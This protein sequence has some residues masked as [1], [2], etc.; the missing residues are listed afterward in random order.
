MLL[1]KRAGIKITLL[2]MAVA[3]LMAFG[4]LTQANAL[5]STN[6]AIIDSP[7]VINGGIFPTSISG[8]T[9][10]NLAVADVNATN[11]AA[12]D[13]VLLNVASPGM[14]CSTGTLSTS[15]KQDLVDF[16]AN[17]GKLIIYDSECPTADY[18]WLPYPF[19]TNNPGALGAHG[20][21]TIVEENT[22]SCSTPGCTVTD[23]N[24]NIT[25]SYIDA[26]SLG[27]NTD[28]V[29]DM[30]V[31]VTRDPNWCL[32]MEGTNALAVEGPVHT[33]ATYY[34]GLIIYNGLDVDYMGWGTTDL[35]KIWELELEQ[36]W[37]PIPTDAATGDLVLPCSELVAC[38]PIALKDTA[39]EL[40]NEALDY[41]EDSNIAS[42]IA[43]LNDAIANEENALQEL[44]DPECYE[45]ASSCAL[46]AA[47]K[48]IG[49]AISRE[50]SAIRA[51]DRS[52][53]KV[54]RARYYIGSSIG[55]LQKADD[56][57]AACDG[58]IPSP[59]NH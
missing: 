44:Q 40:K 42:A 59:C 30:N 6:V 39:I 32:D 17:G 52:Q 49:R 24:G 23:T 15:Q 27:S 29:G 19:D 7:T 22:L 54:H 2:V 57:L 1:T 3:L 10:T 55:M 50:E 51:L 35:D 45:C 33:Y 8:I 56:Y 37:N 13:T 16:V 36:R 41:L 25:D 26:A 18:S 20:T 38:D 47:I 5:T 21:L 9:F 4:S 43:N 11:L 31:M 48:L 14:G 12:Y 53:P 34:N 46:N 58:Q 28:A